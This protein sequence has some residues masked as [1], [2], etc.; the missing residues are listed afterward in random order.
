MTISII[1]AVWWENIQADAVNYFVRSLVESRPHVSSR[2]LKP[3]CPL[4]GCSVVKSLLQADEMRQ[5]S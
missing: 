2:G 3:Q 4:N 5:K 1:K